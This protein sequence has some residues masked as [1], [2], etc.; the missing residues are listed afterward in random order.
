MR[1][2]K[3]LKSVIGL[4]KTDKY[5]YKPINIGQTHEWYERIKKIRDLADLNSWQEIDLQEKTTMISFRK[6]G[7]RMN[8]YYTK[9][10]VGTAMRHPKMGSTQLYRRHVTDEQL[11][12]LMRNPRHH[13]G[14]GY[15]KK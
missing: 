8:I 7:M 3:L 10:T 4:N 9:M 14:R 15:Y 12:K 1:I 2:I 11:Y 13:T 5:K 6:A